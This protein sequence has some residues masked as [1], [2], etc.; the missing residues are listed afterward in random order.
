M[1]LLEDNLIDP[2]QHWYYKY[3]YSQILNCIT[4][5]KPEFKTISDIGAG[6]AVFSMQISRDFPLASFNL[7][8]KNYT[9]KQ[10]INSSSRIKYFKKMMPADVFLLNDV[11]E[12]V[13]KSD[14]FFKSICNLGKDGDLII[15]TVPAFM[16]LW[17]GHDEYLKHFRRYTRGTLL[18][19][20]SGAPVRVIDLRYLYQTLFIPAWIYRK[21]FGKKKKSQL[22]MNNFYVSKF[23]NFFLLVESKLKLKFPFGV[24]LLLVCKID[25]KLV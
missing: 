2:I 5:H 6:S 21:F 22:V 17:S 3:K 25:K 20:I 13:E 14:K 15:I 9:E 16:Q 7:I 11:L 18:R 24:S 10:I 1:D 19:E 4:K 12:H 8:D 23:L